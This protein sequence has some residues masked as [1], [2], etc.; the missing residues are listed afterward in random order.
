MD[1]RVLSVGLILITVWPLLDLPRA[2][3]DNQIGAA[4]IILAVLVL[5]YS[6]LLSTENYF[7]SIAPFS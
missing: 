3:S 7:T 5:V 2:L 1:N 6:L 4:Q